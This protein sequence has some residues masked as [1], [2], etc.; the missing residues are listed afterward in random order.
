M[1]GEVEAG[2]GKLFGLST[3]HR[4]GNMSLIYVGEE[5][6]VMWKGEVG[7]IDLEVSVAVVG[8]VAWFVVLSCAARLLSH[9]ETKFFFHFL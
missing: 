1:E 9:Q 7:L 2:P 5:S 6:E 3:V 4:A 8:C